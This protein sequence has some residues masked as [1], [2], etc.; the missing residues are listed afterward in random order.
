MEH[1]PP[2]NLHI[3]LLIPSSTLSTVTISELGNTTN[4]HV[5]TFLTQVLK[6]NSQ[7]LAK[8]KLSGSVFRK[9]LDI[10]RQ[11]T[12]LTTLDLEL[13]Q[14]NF[15]AQILLV[16]ISRIENLSQLLLTVNKGYGDDLS[17]DLWVHST[18]TLPH[19]F[20]SL[21]RLD[22]LDICADTQRIS[23]FVEAGIKYV[24][25]LTKL[26][27]VFNLLERENPEFFVAL[28]QSLREAIACALPIERCSL[29]AGDIKTHCG[30]FPWKAIEHVQ[31]LKTL[32]ICK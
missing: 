15:T 30:V 16:T 29:R 14:P 24:P 12:A 21:E 2:D 9:T 10:L 27:M 17:L 23:T 5:A 28:E 18:D 4:V 20:K 1:F 7:S 26:S 31:N 25:R 8:L 13:R 19:D 32:K 11:F 6:T 3:L 22:N